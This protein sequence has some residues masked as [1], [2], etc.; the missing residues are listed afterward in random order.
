MRRKRYA[1]LALAGTLMMSGMFCA[2]GE[3]PVAN[4]ISV[5][6]LNSGYYGGTV[7]LNGYVTDEASQ[8]VYLKENQKIEEIYVSPGDRVTKGQA[9]AALDKES[10]RLQLEEEELKNQSLQLQIQ[11]CRQDLSELEKG[12][13]PSETIIKKE[14]TPV[15]GGKREAETEGEE[16]TSVCSI[17]DETSVPV[18]GKGTKKEPY[19]FLVKK[20]CAVMGT[21]FNKMAQKPYWFRLEVREED[22]PEGKVVQAWNGDGSLLKKWHPESRIMLENLEA[23]TELKDALKPVALPEEPTKPEETKP[24][25]SQPEETIPEESQPEE[26]KPEESLP[27]ET[28][29]EESQPEETKPEESQPEETIPEESLPEEIISD[30][31]FPEETLPDSWDGDWSDVWEDGGFHWE[32]GSGKES[33]IEEPTEDP[34]VM[35]EEIRQRKEEKNKELRGLELQIRQSDLNKQN[36]EKDLEQGTINSAVDGVVKYVNDPRSESVSSSDP[37]I[38]VVSQEGWYIMGECKETMLEFLKE[39]D[40]IS[41]FSYESGMSFE[42]EIREIS[43]FPSTETNHYDNENVS[44]YPFI[45]YLENTEGL[46]K[47]EYAELTIP[48]GESGTDGIYLNKAFIRREDGM[49]YV[50]KRG[51]DGTLMRQEVTLGR[52][53]YGENY[54]ILSGLDSEDYIAFPYGKHVKEGVKTEEQSANDFWEEAYG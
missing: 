25:E 17:L 46:K 24:E 19:L 5:A 41:G 38:Q 50:M 15:K 13:I 37:M 42:V 36:L 45:A 40:R 18:T 10:V 26:T 35:A 27:E 22:R 2:C 1:A 28:K 7:S 54:E 53:V 11:K 48:N 16:E 6:E 44:Y 39:G 31:E 30:G 33:W 21:F 23:V 29:P 47:D 4:V 14:M 12:K 49:D 8:N 51:D 9:L 43:R 32:I 20:E 52:I 34:A 3:G